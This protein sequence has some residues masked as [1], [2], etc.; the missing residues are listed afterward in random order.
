MKTLYAWFLGLF[1]PKLL[2]P[3]GPLPAEVIARPSVG[4]CGVTGCPNGRPH[5]HVEDLVRRVRGK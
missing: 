5:S 1:R 4:A 2:Y 3:K